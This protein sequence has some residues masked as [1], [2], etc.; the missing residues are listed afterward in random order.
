VSIRQRLLVIP[1]LVLIQNLA[2][3][4]IQPSH[5]V[6]ESAELPDLVPV[7]RFV[8]NLDYQDNFTVSPDGESMAWNGV[9]GLRPAILWEHDDGE[10][11]GVIAFKKRAPQPFWTGDSRY[12][13]YRSDPSGRENTHVYAIDTHAK[14]H[15]VRDL[16]PGEN[17]RAFVIH[18]PRKA[19]TV[20]YVLHNRR[21]ASRYDLYRIDVATGE[22][23]R[24]HENTETV[25]YFLVDDEGRIV[26]RRRQIDDEQIIERQTENGVWKEIIR[27]TPFDRFHIIDVTETGERLYALSDRNRDKLALVSVDLDTGDETSIYAHPDVD[28]SRVYMSPR[29]R[30]PLI[31]RVTPDYPT[32]VYFDEKFERAFKPLISGKKTGL[33][34]ISMSRDERIVTALTYDVGGFDIYRLDLD[35]GD[36]KLLAT[37]P[38]RKFEKSFTDLDP[39]SLV[40]S[41]GLNLHGYLATPAIAEPGPLPT[42]LLV[43]GGPWSRDTWAFDTMTQFLA[44]RGY[45]VL[46]VNYRGSEGY[47]R[48][49]RD[50][51]VG[52]FAG[53]MHQDLIDAVNWAVENKI[54]DPD[55]VAIMGGSY[56]GYAA[57][58]GMTM[59]PGVFACAVDVVGV[60]DLASLLEDVPPYWETYLPLWHKFV[61]DPSNPVD[62]ADMDKRSPINY[63]ARA[64]GP[65]LII[66]GANDPR[67]RLDQSDRMVRALEDAGKPVEYHVIKKEG[68][69]FGHWKNQL[70]YLRK[71]EDFLADCLGGRSSGFDFY[72]LGSW[73]F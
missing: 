27:T 30:R 2:G 19:S 26:V 48:K 58:V 10:H 70:S 15:E 60:T 23:T 17:V 43:H 57:L 16:T 61:G 5:P 32:V 68:H 31:G 62:R 54:T 59:T 4:A 46:R 12:L 73:A 49:H 38:M 34:I 50:A 56:G 40:A 24:L 20:V 53:A 44:N 28:L 1:I 13:L 9:S 37:S 33:R 14:N 41:D 18:V 71:S 47:G 63:A 3:C 67:V 29:D 64:D 8:A 11:N 35:S 45:A 6:L 42:V 22:E 21:D 36:R 39:V 72:Q 55:H 25:T 52:E 66:H 69:G 7:R 51:A 65:I